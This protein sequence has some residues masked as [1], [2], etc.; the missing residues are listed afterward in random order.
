[1][2]SMSEP[3]YA[4]DSTITKLAPSLQQ[5]LKDLKGN[6]THHDYLVAL[7]IVLS[8]ECGFRVSTSD[9]HDSQ[10]SNLKSLRIPENWKLEHTEIYDIRFQFIATPNI[11]C[12]LVAIPSG[13]LLIIN[14]DPL[15]DHRKTYSICV[16]TLKYINPFSGDLCDR[17]IN[18]KEI[19]LRFK[20]SVIIPLRADVAAREGVAVPSLQHLPLEL[21]EKIMGMLNVRDRTNLLEILG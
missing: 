11:V 15:I 1:M 9:T 6:A 21:R 2:S 4:E 13:D 18:L 8:A 5:I 10:C 14:F 7:L 19:S 17:Y 16:Q 20:D 12:R 3:I